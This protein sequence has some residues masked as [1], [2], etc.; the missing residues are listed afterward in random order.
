M[1]YKIVSPSVSESDVG[2]LPEVKQCGAVQLEDF[3]NCCVSMEELFPINNDVVTEEE[4]CRHYEVLATYA[5]CIS[6][7]PMD[8]GTAKGVKHTIDTGSA[9]PIQVPPRRVA[10]HKEKKY[11][12]KWMKCW[13]QR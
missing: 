1:T 2:V 10:F 5:N 3:E 8:L 13:R 11:A 6:R 7:G 4:K 9:Q 12:V